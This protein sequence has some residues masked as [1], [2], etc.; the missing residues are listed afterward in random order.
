MKKKIGILGGTFD[1]PHFGHL[2]IADQVRE[3]CQLEKILFMP[4]NVPPHKEGS[5]LVSNEDRIAMIEKAIETNPYFE[6]SLEEI[7]R[8]GRSYTIDTIKSLKQKQPDVDVYFII[9]GD[10]VEYLPKWKDIDELLTLV[11]FVGVNRPGHEATSPYREQLMMIEAPQ[12]EISS[13]EIRSRLLE[14]RTIRYLLPEVVFQHIK[15]HKLY[16]EGNCVTNC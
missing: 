2:L 13:S 15:E 12:L 8:K 14:R 5:Y 6:L 9:G 7:E 4:T 1:P 10:M 16:G 3:A 11:T